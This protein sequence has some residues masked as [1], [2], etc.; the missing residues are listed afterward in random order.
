MGCNKAVTHDTK[1][2]RLIINELE[3]KRSG[4]TL[5]QTQNVLAFL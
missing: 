4:Q 3:T 2:V 5:R 1:T